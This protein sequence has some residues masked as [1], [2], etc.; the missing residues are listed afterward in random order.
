MKYLQANNNDF[1]LLISN[2]F[3]IANQQLRI[4]NPPEYLVQEVHSNRGYFAYEDQI[5]LAGATTAPAVSRLSEHNK[6]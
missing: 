1:S 6:A 3:I 5:N 4:E 2:L